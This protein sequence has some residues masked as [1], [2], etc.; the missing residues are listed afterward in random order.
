MKLSRTFALA[1]IVLRAHIL[2]PLWRSR[3]A[4]RAHRCNVATVAIPRYLKR[5]IPAPG[6]V[7]E[8]PAQKPA[9]KY[10]PF[11]SKV[12]K[13]RRRW[14]RHAGAVCVKIAQTRI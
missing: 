12:K 5:Y 13:M 6:T 1:D 10:S 4:R 8:T 14:S 9:R 2:N 3:D 11:G 7:A